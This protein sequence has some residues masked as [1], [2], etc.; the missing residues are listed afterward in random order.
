MATKSPAQ[1]K[2]NPNATYEKIF[3]ADLSLPDIYPRLIR[4][5]RFDEFRQIKNL[6]I[7]F[8]S[9]V[10]VVSG[11]N[12]CGKTTMLLSIACSHFDFK[13]RNYSNG[14]LERQTWSDVL[15][16]TDY[17]K[18][19]T[20]W[21]YHLKIKTGSKLED[22]RGQRKKDTKKW[23]GLG[24]KESQITD[25]A[26]VYLDLDRILPA[27]YFSSVLHKRAQAATGVDVSKINQKY[28]E[29]CFS[30]IFEEKYTLKKLADHLG[31]DLLGFSVSNDYSSFNSA[32]GED[33]LS[34]ILI[35]CIEAPKKSLIL[36]DELELGLHPKIQRRL[37]DVIFDVSIKDQKQFVI[38]SHSSTVISSVP[39][40]SRVFIDA[41]GLT[42][43]AISPIS[44]NATLSRM[45]SYCYP[46]VDLFCEDTCA[47]KII[48]KA[49]SE[50]QKRATSCVDS[51]LIN[52]IISGSASETFSNFLVRKRIY[53]KVTIKSGHACVLDGDMRVLK[54][55]TG[56]DQ[57]PAQSGLFFLPGMFPPEKVLCD[58][59]ELANN[60][61]S[62]RYHIDNSNVHCLF[63]KMVELGLSLNVESAFE[64][65]WL[66]FLATSTGKMGFEQ[67]IDFLTDECRR[68]SSS[69]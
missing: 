31:K 41:V 12:R 6:T 46:L 1:Y 56:E 63:D 48:D 17:D 7:D 52:V 2:F 57:F 28:I 8:T 65:S 11:S 42:Q 23:N 32:S 13:K 5:V 64:D 51:K 20:D 62:L 53:E 26:V 37:M 29:E 34:R 67:L 18:Q 68:Y 43:Q 30:Y 4:Q 38:T 33:V 25:V 60:N 54:S 49:R 15:K 36:I 22:R 3:K 21:T 69:L 24:K 55:K 61:T 66:A 10:T 14:K 45:D 47:A 19:A 16:F 58:C 27:R 44:I 35:D 39:D 59:Y 40:T 9:P 50:M